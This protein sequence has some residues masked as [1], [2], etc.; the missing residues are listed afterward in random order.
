M[1]GSEDEEGLD[2]RIVPL[3]AS[4]IDALMALS[5]AAQWNQNESDWRT[6]LTLGQGWGALAADA[7]GRPRLVASTV[8]LPYE[9]RFAWIS[10]VLV[11][12]AWRERGLAGQLLEVALAELDA[13]GLPQVLD[14]TP[15]GHPVYARQGFV[16]T[17]GF[18]RWRRLGGEGRVGAARPPEPL[19]RGVELRALREADW[20]ALAALDGRA[21]GASRLPLLQ[22]LA[23]RLPA[24]AWVMEREG[25]LCG[26][27][28]GR[29]GRT[30]LQLGP[31]V[32]EPGGPPDLACA[33]LGTA[34]EALRQRTVGLPLTLIVD[35]RDGQAEL[36]TWLKERG[37]AIERPFT[38]MVR[39]ADGAPGD[40]ARVVLVAGPE[41]G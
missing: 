10:M 35:L 17:W 2:T 8:A 32:V 5:I 27:L 13:R 21:F 31:L 22:Q 28:L 36:Q 15:A 29:D 19:P 1:R 40:A 7:S 9:S 23:R 4:M 25:R 38:R 18:V 37:F 20:P 6:M 11:L 33:L 24:A 34:L 3:D 16:D 39:G 26:F 12:P 30:A 14:A 41:L